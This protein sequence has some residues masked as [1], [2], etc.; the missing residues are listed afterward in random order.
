M[1]IRRLVQTKHCYIIQ[2][3]TPSGWVLDFTYPDISP[4]WLDAPGDL[5]DVY[6]EAAGWPPNFTLV[7]WG[8]FCYVNILPLSVIE[9][10]FWICLIAVSTATFTAGS[11]VNMAVEASAGFLV[12]DVVT[13]RT[14]DNATSESATVTAVPDSTHIT[15]AI[16]ANT[17]T[18]A[19]ATPPIVRKVIRGAHP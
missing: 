15:V 9:Q 13:V 17:Y 10:Q 14:F 2:D 8:D 1:D 5:Q 7:Q 12:D 6:I 4:V 19:S 3:L 16:L 11:S 18:Y